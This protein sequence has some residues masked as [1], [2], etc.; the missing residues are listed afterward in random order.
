MKRKRLFLCGATSVLML[1]G[2]AM[3]RGPEAARTADDRAPVNAGLLSADQSGDREIVVVGNQ[4]TTVALD[5]PVPVDVISQD[6]LGRTGT[7]NLNQSLQRLLPSF[8]FPQTQN[9]VKG[10]YGTRSASLRRLPPDLTLVLVDGQRRNP[11]S[12][13]FAVDP[14][15]VGQFVDLSAIPVNAIDRVEVLR[16]GASAQYGSDA[17]AGVVNL[18]LKKRTEGNDATAQVGE[19]TRGDG[20]MN[21]LGFTIATALPGDGFLDVSANGSTRRHTDR[22]G[23]DWRQRYF[24]GDAREQSV[25][26]NSV[27]RW[28]NADTDNLALLANFEIGLTDTLRFY[29]TGNYAITDT[30]NRVNP[31]EPKNDGNLRAFNPDGTQPEIRGKLQDLSAVAGVRFDGGA[32]GQFDLSVNAG[33]NVIRS[34]LKDSAS[35]S[36]GLASQ[37]SFYLGRYTGSQVAANLGYQRDIELGLARPASLSAGLTYRTER[38]R[39]AEAGDEQSWNNGGVPILDGSNAGKAARYGADVQGLTPGDLYAI[40]RHVWGGFVGADLFPVKGITIGGALRY[41]RYSDFGDTATGKIDAR[42]DVT[43]WFAIRGGWSTGFHAPAIAALGTQVTAS[44]TIFSFSGKLD[45]SLASRTRQ[46]RPGD[47]AVAPLGARSLRP[48]KARNFSGGVVVRPFDGAS[49]TIDAYQIEIDGFILL[50]DGANANGL[51]GAFVQSVTAAA[52][53]PSVKTVSFFVNG[54]DTRTR[55]IDAVARYRFDLASD[56]D[57]DLSLAFS[58]G[59]TRLYN[60]RQA[61]AGSGLTYFSRSRLADIDKGVPRWKLVGGA[62]GTR[63]RFDLSLNQVV[64]GPYTYTHPTIAA[65]DQRYDPQWVT[66]LEAGYRISDATRFAIGTQNLFDT[67]PAQYIRANQVNGIN[68]YGFIHPDGSNGRFI[69]ATL[70]HKL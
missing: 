38:W 32:A 45:E 21:S 5:S 49:L 27:G 67:Y 31:T 41:E 55:G 61:P 35:P 30:R 2:P 60:I 52:G 1:A 10:T 40:S 50:T 64:Y 59:K 8:N 25:D 13:L 42:W 56:S 37:R 34:Y 26:R 28:G 16:D 66:D 14:Y 29:G 11:S 18:I 69:Y 58:T 47:P 48:E 9:A 4:R 22:S 36:Y 3:A 20:F 7:V 12:R 54:L 44:T 33:R 68:R 70:S 15:R 6:T 51:T 46:F 63:G 65:N 57:I 39:A 23:P 17:I 62:R 19:Y 24:A 53:L 43:D